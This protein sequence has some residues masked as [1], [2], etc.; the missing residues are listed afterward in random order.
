MSSYDLILVGSGFASSFFLYEYLRKAP[1]NAR[2]LVLER[3]PAAP[4]SW[5][6]ENLKNSPINHED[7]FIQENYGEKSWNFTV[8]FGGSSN[9]WWAGTPRMLPNDFRLRSS[10]GVGRDWP[11]SY[12][13]LEQYYCEAETIMDVSG[14][15][16]LTLIA[17][18][19]Q[20]YPQPAHRFTDPDFLL[21]RAHPETFYQQPSA[22]AR[23]TTRDRVACCANA[24]CNLCPVDAKFTIQNGLASIYEDPRVEVL[25]KAEALGVE[26]SAGLATGVRYRRDS[27]VRTATGELIAL[28]ANA[29]FNPYLLLRSGLDHPL[30]GRRLHEQVS[31]EALVYLDGVDNFQGSTSVTGLGFML[32]D[33]LHR[34]EHAGCMIETWNK[35]MVRTEF[36]KWRQILQ[37][38]VV[39]E[40]LPLE[41]NRIYVS[42]DLLSKPVVFFQ[43]RSEYALVGIRT[44]GDRLTQ[45][46][47]VL[48]VERIE[49]SDQPAPTESHS[50]GTTAMGDSPTTSIV[51]RH[52]LHH[53]IR[54]LLV[55]GGSVFPTTPP[56]NPTLTISALSLYAARNL[57]S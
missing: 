35:P 41:E 49:V 36:G 54:N 20:L 6:L 32:Y 56:A 31:V 4:H 29:I 43:R 44:L 7:T 40:D 23:R 45:I 17:P 3:G 5:Q 34:K 37:L 48:P 51:D 12:D 39:F 10:Y 11:L 27:V 46:F 19:S 50:L 33:G 8:A 22:R 52:L 42:D 55:L 21:K 26:T 47:E 2:L 25:L 13:M 9:A 16:D 53:Q 15:D 1:K 14:P 18:R 28:G 57:M 30:L 38:R 24:V